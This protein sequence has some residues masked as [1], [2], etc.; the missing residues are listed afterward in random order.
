MEDDCTVTRILNAAEGL[1][2]EQGFT[3]TSL[4]TI[5]SRAGVNL[6]SVNYHF[7]GKKE[8]IQAVFARF[9]TPFCDRLATD[10]DRY[11]QALQGELP[12][13]DALLERM[14]AA[15]LESC[16]GDVERLGVFMTLLSAAYSQ[17]QGHLRR[18][19][20]E[21][22]GFLFN[23]YM[24]KIEQAS[25][26]LSPEDRFWRIHFMMGA[27]IFILSDVKPLSAMAEYDFGQA[28][29]AE[30]VLSRLVSF[31]SAGFRSSS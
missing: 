24:E 30:A 4:R 19:M 18:F 6:A 29:S 5:T 13:L 11:D 28:P 16:S 27:A 10:L 17:R 9:L 12:E 2:A 20:R 21:T 14:V 3:E 31:L 15:A 23:R 22:Y 25:P 1:F 8:L 7:G 26:E